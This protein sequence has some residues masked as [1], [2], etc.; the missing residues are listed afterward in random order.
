MTKSWWQL[1]ICQSGG[2]LVTVWVTD[3]STW[4]I[5]IIHL[6]PEPGELA[7]EYEYSGQS[8]NL[9]CKLMENSVKNFKFLFWVSDPCTLEI[10]KLLKVLS[11]IFLARERM[12]YEGQNRSVI[13]DHLAVNYSVC[14]IWVKRI[15]SSPWQLRWCP[16]VLSRCAVWPLALRNNEYLETFNPGQQSNKTQTRKKVQ[17][18]HI[19]YVI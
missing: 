12:N 9:Y 4:F 19:Q 18:Y 1:T 3:V 8:C 6:W 7:R 15:L 14:L 17:Y 10:E 2:S 5:L 11:F 16:D 13:Y